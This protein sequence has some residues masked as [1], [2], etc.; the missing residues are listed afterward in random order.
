METLATK[1]TP[2]ALQM[3]GVAVRSFRDPA[4]LV[5]EGIDWSV[6]VGDYWVIAG[7]QGS[8]KSD[9]LMM[10]GSLMA[11][12]R[13]RYRLFDEDMPIFEDH[14]LKARL[15]LGL[16]FDGGQLFNHLTVA[17]NVALPLRYHRNLSQQEAA[18]SVRELLDAMELTPWAD[19]APAMLRRSWQKR[20]GLA[21]ALA[22]QP[23]ILLVDNPLGGLD[24][25]HTNWWLG[26]LDH[27]AKGHPLTGGRPVTLVIT[28]A[29]L[30]PWKGH[31]RQ[32]A[33]LKN[34][35]LCVLGTWAQLRAA[36][37][38]LLHELLTERAQ[39]EYTEAE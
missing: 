32:F 17:E 36:S 1:A 39:T 27:L 16:V 35:R 21:R 29:D 31:A 30:R 38:E 14:R 34:Q 4:A 15:R 22:L 5:A 3:E 25:P 11:P 19:H 37:Q 12:Q 26:F 2:P 20:A 9:F 33:I 24:L 23:E 7:L 10:A 28:T 18:A 8:G 6:A 13:G